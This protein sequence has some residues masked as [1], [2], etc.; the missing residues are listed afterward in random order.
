VLSTHLQGKS[1]AANRRK[2]Y[3]DYAKTLL[4]GNVGRL[5]GLEEFLGLSH[6]NAERYR[7]ERGYRYD[8]SLCGEPETDLAFAIIVGH[9]APMDKGEAMATFLKLWNEVNSL[10]HVQPHHHRTKTIAR[11]LERRLELQQSEVRAA[12]L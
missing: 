3:Q 9:L 2:A 1:G 4:A 10:L 11:I 8:S 7:L 12:I 5:L 6:A